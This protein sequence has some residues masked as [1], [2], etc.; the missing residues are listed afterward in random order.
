MDVLVGGPG[1]VYV[2]SV[3]IVAVDLRVK[4]RVNNQGE[5]HGETNVKIML[6]IR[7][8]IRVNIRGNMNGHFWL[9]LSNDMGG[10]GVPTFPIFSAR[11][12]IHR[13]AFFTKNSRSIPE[14][15]R[16]IFAGAHSPLAPPSPR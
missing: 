5:N 13:A 15:S 2:K 10:D 4:I 1:H 7:V 3:T 16:I 11:I 8:K 12:P 9:T 14:P 6:K